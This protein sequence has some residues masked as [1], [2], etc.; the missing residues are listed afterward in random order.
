MGNLLAGVI[1]VVFL[2]ELARGN[3]NPSPWV[4]LG[5]VSGLSYM[6][7]LLWFVRRS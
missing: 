4:P 5:V 6:A 2:V 7:G 1:V 3:L